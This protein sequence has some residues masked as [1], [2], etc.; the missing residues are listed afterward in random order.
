VLLTF[1]TTSPLV[2]R[3][4]SKF[5]VPVTVEVSWDG[6]TLCSHPMKVCVVHRPLQASI[7]TGAGGH[8]RHSEYRQDK[9][10]RMNVQSCVDVLDIMKKAEDPQL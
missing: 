4:A 2:Q 9:I 8:D 10:H 7:H 6:Y 5:K 1:C 3:L